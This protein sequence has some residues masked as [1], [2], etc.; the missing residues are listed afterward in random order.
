LTWDTLSEPIPA[1]SYRRTDFSSAGPVS[2]TPLTPICHLPTPG[3]E[4]KDTCEMEID[5]MRIFG[6][7][8]HGI[9][10]PDRKFSVL[11]GSQNAIDCRNS[12]S[13]RCSRLISFVSVQRDFFG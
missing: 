11:F 1:N 7:K 10:I 9:G 4:M 3:G 6:M 13:V 5:Q 2:E 8:S 12:G